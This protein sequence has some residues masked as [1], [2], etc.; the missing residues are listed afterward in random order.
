MRK[1]GRKER[2]RY[3]FVQADQGGGK[4]GCVY[5]AYSITGRVA[6]LVLPQNVYRILAK[7]EKRA[8]KNNLYRKLYAVAKSDKKEQ[9]GM[10]YAEKRRGVG[11][12][13]RVFRQPSKGRVVQLRGAVSPQTKRHN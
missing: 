4:G 1:S 11:A 9:A 12:R 10:R 3:T 7:D 2:Q 13:G 5:S 8:R 6:V